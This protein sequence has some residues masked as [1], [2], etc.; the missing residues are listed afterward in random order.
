MSQI[1]LGK[2]RPWKVFPENLRWGKS[3][4]SVFLCMSVAYVAY[5]WQE[6]RVKHIGKSWCELGSMT[7][8]NSFFLGG[9]YPI[10]DVR[11]WNLSVCWDCMISGILSSGWF[12]WS[13]TQIDGVSDY[14]WDGCYCNSITGSI[15]LIWIIHVG[16]SSKLILACSWCRSHQNEDEH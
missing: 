16:D 3:Q 5:L 4:T 12:D 9:T 13:V 10:N 14:K 8:L 11:W 6:K 7:K 15:L 1:D 2:P